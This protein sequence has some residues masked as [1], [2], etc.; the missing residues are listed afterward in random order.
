MLS[1]PISLEARPQGRERQGGTRAYRPSG[2]AA[3]A[4]T[5]AHYCVSKLTAKPIVSYCCMCVYVCV[6]FV[7]AFG[8]A[9]LR[10]ARTRQLFSR[11]R[12][13]V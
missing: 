2:C 12:C 11:Q 4:V 5:H 3:T 8:V 9:K 13:S 1:F 6:V 10:S 7:F